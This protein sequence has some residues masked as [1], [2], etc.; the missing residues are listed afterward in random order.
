MN[1]IAKIIMY[2]YEQKGKCT[3]DYCF[4][5]FVKCTSITKVISFV[6]I[7]GK[8]ANKTFLLK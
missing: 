8:I 5:K 3:V 1:T 6:M 2:S 7:S 4:L